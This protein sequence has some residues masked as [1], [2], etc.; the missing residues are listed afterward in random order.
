MQAIH[1]LK[2]Y[3]NLSPSD[4]LVF[5]DNGDVSFEGSIIGNIHDFSP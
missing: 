3:F 4:N 1:K 2:E 5:H